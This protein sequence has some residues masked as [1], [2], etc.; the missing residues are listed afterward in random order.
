VP[1]SVLTLRRAV[2]ADADTLAR[3]GWLGQQTWR[4][5]APPTWTPRSHAE[6][7]ALIRDVLSLPDA[8]GLLAFVDGEPAGHCVMT[9]GY[10]TEPRAALLGALFVR[11]RWFGTG[12]AHTL[13]E[14]FIA[15]ATERDYPWAWLVTP[16]GHARA[17]RF[18]ERRGWRADTLLE[19]DRGMPWAV[20]GRSLLPPAAATREN[21]AVDAG[22]GSRP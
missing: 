13:H 5:F 17:R 4:A 19:H 20:Y 16:A 12:L 14:A 2:P 10:W 7:V 22:V 9:R 1:R 15:E 8:W 21:R 6:G 18:Y 11:P 3:T